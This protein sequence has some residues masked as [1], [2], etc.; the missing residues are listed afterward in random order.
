LVLIGQQ[1][2]RDVRPPSSSYVPV[3]GAHGPLSKVMIRLP[4]EKLYSPL[5]AKPGVSPGSRFTS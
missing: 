1:I 3:A 4:A 2:H 5:E